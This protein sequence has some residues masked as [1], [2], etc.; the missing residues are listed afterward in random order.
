MSTSKDY[1]EAIHGNRWKYAALGFLL[2][3]FLVLA[4]LLIIT[5]PIDPVMPVLIIIAIIL[6]VP[7]AVFVIDLYF[8]EV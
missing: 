1:K 8:C 5:A 4:I 3:V 2:L 6:L 7:A